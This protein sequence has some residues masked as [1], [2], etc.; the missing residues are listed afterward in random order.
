MAFL[1]EQLPYFDLN[2][3]DLVGHLADDLVQPTPCNTSSS[4]MSTDILYDLTFDIK[5]CQ[6]DRSIS[7]NEPDNYFYE[8]YKR[9]SNSCKYFVDNL[10]EC[11]RGHLSMF[12]H[13]IN[14]LPKH[15]DELSNLLDVELKVKFNVISLC[16]TKL[17]PDISH[18]YRIEGYTM[19]NRCNSRN[20]GGL[21]CY[22]E[23]K[24]KN[25]FVREDL[26]TSSESTEFLFIEVPVSGSQKNVVIGVIYRRPGTDFRKFYENLTNVLDILKL[27]KKICYFMGDFNLDLLKFHESTQ[28]SDFV[29][30]LTSE[31][32][33]CSITHPTRV[34]HNTATLIDHIWCNNYKNLSSCGIIHSMITDHFPVFSVFNI[35]ESKKHENIECKDEMYFR[36]FSE[37]K[38]ESFKCVLD[39]VCWDL[40]V[41]INNIEAS[42]SNFETI[43]GALISKHFPMISKKIPNGHKNKP[44]ITSNIK[45]LINSKK[46]LAKLYAKYPITYGKSFRKLRNKIANEIRN[47]KIKY[48]S[49]KLNSCS[50]DTS[51]TWKVINTI[52]NRKKEKTK[53]NEFMINGNSESNTEII[54]ESFNDH[55]SDVGTRLAADLPASPVSYRYFLGVRT[56]AEFL[57]ESVTREKIKC[58]VGS[59]KNCSAGYDDIPMKVI[60]YCIDSLLEPLTHICNLSLQSGTV[61]KQLK[62][63]K[64]TPIFKTGKN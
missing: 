42:Y 12:F 60:K 10:P 17:T 64:L 27:E 15:F 21:T 43:F 49:E 40:V 36:S 8:F 59:L 48:F 38:L 62:I 30:L 24:F 7:N 33:L 6:D 37:E 57:F 16:E 22:I 51:E 61:P 41:G 25:C 54:A 63:S 19:F 13:N 4:I 20:K 1:R 29:N 35:G 26:S 23:D 9:I 39:G 52:L 18:L 53:I 50:S 5:S 47:S 3:E 58:T 56:D 55:Y 46:K 2:N 11:R 31:N 34:T 32:Y 45:N 14:S 44:Y 28:V